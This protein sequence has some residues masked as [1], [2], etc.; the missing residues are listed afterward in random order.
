MNFSRI[1]PV[2]HKKPIRE[3]LKDFLPEPDPKIVNRLI[4]Y[5]DYFNPRDR[6]SFYHHAYDL[7]NVKFYARILTLLAELGI[8]PP[9]QVQMAGITPSKIV[10]SFDGPLIFAPSEPASTRFLRR[11]SNSSESKENVLSGEAGSLA[12]A[13][14]GMLSDID[15]DGEDQV[16]TLI[17][18]VHLRRQPQIHLDESEFKESKSIDEFDMDLDDVLDDD[19]LSDF[20]GPQDT[21]V[22]SLDDFKDVELIDEEEPEMNIIRQTT[23][24]NRAVEAIRRIRGRLPLLRIPNERRAEIELQIQQRA[25]FTIDDDNV[26]DDDDLSSNPFNPPTPTPIAR[27][28][29][30][31]M[32]PSMRRRFWIWLRYMGWYMLIPIA[33]IP[34]LLLITKKQKTEFEDPLVTMFNQLKKTNWFRNQFPTFYWRDII[35]NS[36]RDDNFLFLTQM[37]GDDKNNY[38]YFHFYED[39][40]LVWVILKY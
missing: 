6:A 1:R 20:R 8:Y 15:S 28:W 37:L 32:D 18:L 27:Q 25:A 29:W 9:V 11:T 34:Q 38:T 16:L 10:S 17:E 7:E 30:D 13:S 3:R 2:V 31:R 40:V 22:P 26:W 39:L 36:S 24:R 12:D 35:A 23:I 14:E 21:K 4:S 33:L 19:A 5:F